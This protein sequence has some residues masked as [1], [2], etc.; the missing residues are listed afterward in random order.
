M[1]CNSVVTYYSPIPGHWSPAEDEQ[2]LI[3]LWQHSWRKYGWD[4]IVLTE[5][6]VKSHP[7]YAF[8]HEVFSAKPSEYGVA[9]CN[10][11]WLR[12]LAAAHYS[13]LR[14]GHTMLVDYDVINYGL[15]PMEIIPGQMQILC[16]EPP[17]SVFAGSFFG[18]SQHFLDMT[19]LFAAWGPDE[20]DFNHHAQCL[21]QDDLSML[22]RMFET[23][24]RPKPDWLVK[25]PG[26]ALWDYS[27]CRSSKLVHY[28]YALYNA[29]KKP[30][31][32]VIPGLRSI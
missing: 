13:S 2:K 29:Y 21:H 27:S 28:G 1:I 30:K 31:Y 24:T 25:V 23:K 20:L 19:E 17:A 6:D 3:E 26:T 10:A 7:R 8:F 32:Q 9:Y 5:A 18:S 14:T 15:E 16:D 22:V 11:C 12:W 4:S